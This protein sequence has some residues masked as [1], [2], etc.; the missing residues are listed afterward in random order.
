MR[1]LSA[2][3]LLHVFSPAW[4]VEGYVLGVGVQADSDDGLAGSVLVDVALTE[5]TWLSAS[6]GGYSAEVVPDVDLE[7]TNADLGID[8]WFDPVGIRVSAAYWGDKEVLHSIDG[9]ASLYWRKSNVRLSL[10][11]QYRDFDFDLFE[12]DF[13][14]GRSVRFHAKGL[15]ASA[16]FDITDTLSANF[17]GRDYNYN[18]N[19]NIDANRRISELLSVS[20][21]SLLNSLVDYRVGAGVN[22]AVGKRDWSLDY[23]ASKGEV[24]GIHTNSLTLR[25]L[26][27]LTKNSDIE[28]GLGVDDN[29]R[30]GRS[31]ILSVFWY[32]YGG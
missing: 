28:F 10:D 31:T 21:L 11:L 4:A 32:F 1:W 23:A 30:F 15:G 17:F 27:P 7:T 5:K 9:N 25:F 2:A 8:H 19:L 29:E 16:R 3:F 26:T 14:Q 6:A 24:A 18:V 22:L 20:R 13:L 12:R